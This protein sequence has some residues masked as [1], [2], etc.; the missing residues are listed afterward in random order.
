VKEESSGN[1]VTSFFTNIFTGSP[2]KKAEAPVTPGDDVISADQVASIEAT[3]KAPPPKKR[4]VKPVKKPA[5]KVA[6][7]TPPAKK[8][9]AQNTGGRSLYHLQ[10]GVFG[11][12]QAADRFVSR[13]NKKFGPV[14]GSKT[15][16]VVETDLG[17][18]RRQYRVY[19]GPFRSRDKGLKSCKTLTKLGMG[20][21]LVE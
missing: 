17:Q 1:S 19:L 16:M 20:C 2:E 8:P 4:A 7:R 6:A 15:A 11:E 10:L 5:R 14:V 21:R 12:A 3:K 9:L 18:S 13:L